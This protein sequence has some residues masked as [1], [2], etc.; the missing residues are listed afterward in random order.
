MTVRG[1]QRSAVALV[2]LAVTPSAGAAH[3][4]ALYGEPK[5]PEGFAHFDYVN[6]DAP[7]GGTLRLANTAAATFDS[8]NPYILRGTA[9]AG[10]GQVFDTLTV[11]SLDEPFTEYGLVA[12]DIEIGPGREWVRYRL[13]EAARFHD[14]KPI[15]AEDV[16]FSFRMLR[17]DGHPQYRF[18]YRNVERV[19]AEGE[20]TVTF[21][22][23]DGDNRELPLIVGQLPV[24]P[25]H[26]WEDREFDR[27]TL[28]P[29]LGSGP[30]RIAEVDPG[31]RIVYERVEDYWAEELPVNRGRYNFDRIT[32][33]Y[34]R[35][36][37][38]AVEA[39]KGGDYDL[40]TENVAKNW[41]TAYDIRAL[42]DGRLVKQEIEHGLPFGA[43]GWFFNTRRELFADPRVR[44]AIGYAFDF[45]WTNRQLFHGAYKR[46]ESYFANSELAAEGPPAEAERAVLEPYREQLPER[47][48]TEDFEPPSTVGE[49]GLRANLRRAVELL[50][51]A[52]YGI[53]DGTMVH[54]DSGEALAFEILLDSASMERV[55]LPFVK[56]LQRLGID[57]EVRTVD[58]TQ[59]QNRV[60]SFDYD[61][62]VERIPQS[63]SPGNEQRDYWSCEAAR[64]PGSQNYAGIC[65]D[66]IDALVSGLINAPSR[67]ALVTRTRALDR[68][69]LW[70]SYMIPHWYSGNFRLVYW[71]KFGQPEHAPPYGL[72]LD[73]WW[74]DSEKAARIQR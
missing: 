37:T 13:R 65:N 41:A 53:E 64:T 21:H 71:D 34:Y 28:E 9:A 5:Y 72:A 43:Q 51:E 33:D 63:L 24:L 38:V 22:F 6:P 29:P 67:E 12:G 30:Y 56:N 14:G 39:L 8:L 2:I 60:Q 73:S 46:L 31:N 1:W 48:F 68:A 32:Y 54:Q 18:Y 27:T 66:A 70:G 25:R 52:G 50:A 47:V 23:D 36:A 42:E 59:Y 19:E 3:A 40:R 55:T 20:R 57:A 49:G 58:P 15:T 62:I 61:M 74:V 10:L 35:D 17:E 11:R 7:K 26:Y 45:P 16:V 4:V 44:E 69:L